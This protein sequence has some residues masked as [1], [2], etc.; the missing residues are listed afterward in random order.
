M[1]K[2]CSPKAELASLSQHRNISGILTRERDTLEARLPKN[3]FIRR[4][5]NQAEPINIIQN[6][7]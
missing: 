2:E 3:A 5:K 6:A 4:C 7:F 1:Y